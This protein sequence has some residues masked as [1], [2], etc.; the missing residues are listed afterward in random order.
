M[1]RQTLTGK[2]RSFVYQPKEKQPN[3]FLAAQRIGQMRRCIEVETEGNVVH[4]V[5]VT[6]RPI[7]PQE[8][9]G[10]PVPTETKPKHVELTQELLHIELLNA[11][12]TNFVTDI[13][14]YETLTEKQ[15]NKLVA[16]ADAY[17]D[18]LDKERA[19]EQ[20]RREI[21]EAKKNSPSWQQAKA[22]WNLP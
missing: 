2:K 22:R 10:L 3:P 12:E 5:G 1:K 20:V 16:I 7:R 13:Q 4:L 21:R 9:P 11:W 19:A 8:P 6:T 14:K 15:R 17:G 18:E